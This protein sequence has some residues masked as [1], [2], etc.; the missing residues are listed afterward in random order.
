VLLAILGPNWLNAKDESGQRR[1]DNPAD[2]VR[3]EIAAALARKIR[4]VPVLIDGARVPKADELPDDLKP[5]VRRNAIELRNSQ[6]ARDADA[7]ADHILLARPPDRARRVRWIAL[8]AG[9]A[10]LLL[11][12][13]GWIGLHQLGVAVPWPWPPSLAA[14]AA[15]ELMLVNAKTGK[16]LTIAGGATFD[17]NVDAAQLDC[18]R[19]PLRRWWLEEQTNGEGIYKIKNVQTTRCLT[20][21]GGTSPANYVRALQFFC[22]D[23]P[24][25]TWRISDVGGGL[26]QIRNVHT[27]KCLTISDRDSPENSV[28]AGAPVQY[29]CDADPSGRWTLRPKPS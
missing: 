11:L 7:L 19:D 22:D 14:L 17:P 10:A 6:F 15:S 20:I 9:P 1:L 5:L 3:V 29:D 28:L 2:Y 26:Y 16:C 18:D 4:V 25:R 27:H 23:D 24:S 8:A 12:L 21:A 13:A